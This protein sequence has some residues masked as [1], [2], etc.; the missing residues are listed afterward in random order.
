[1]KQKK[2]I[3][4]AAKEKKLTKAMQEEIDRLLANV[5]GLQQQFNQFIAFCR[6]EL[7]CPPDWILHY[8]EKTFLSPADPRLGSR[9]PDEVKIIK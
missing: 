8:Q 6:S 2:T 7:G 4:V 5:T 9:K 1:M 3:V